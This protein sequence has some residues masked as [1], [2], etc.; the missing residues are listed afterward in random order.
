MNSTNDFKN[1]RMISLL[2]LISIICLFIGYKLGQKKIVIVASNDESEKVYAVVDGK[3][4][5]GKSV[6]DK[7][8]LDLQQLEKNKY[9]LKKA[10]VEEMIRQDFSKELAANEITTNKL[11]DVKPT[12]P[13]FLQFTKSNNIDLKKINKKDLNDLIGNFS[14][15]KK[16]QQKKNRI[17]TAV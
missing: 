13:D 4:Y 12:D 1:I 5:L 9:L 17:R 16:M 8:K 6:L 15:Q 7:I 14:I 10:S 3:K 2:S 11:F